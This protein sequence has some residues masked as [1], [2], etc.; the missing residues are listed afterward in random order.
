M[1]SILYLK[2]KDDFNNINAKIVIIKI[3]ADWCIPCKTISPLYNQFAMKNLNENIL[4]T[5]INTNDADD[6]LLDFIDVKTLPTFHIYQDKKLINTLIG[7]DKIN[8]SMALNN[9]TI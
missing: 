5:E 6:E 8:L 3:S 7:S 9:L 4:Y 2:T 1:N